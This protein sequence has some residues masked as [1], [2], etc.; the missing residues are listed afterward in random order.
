MTLLGD[1]TM[2]LLNY[3]N[4]EAT[5]TYGY[6]MK[7]IDLE[8]KGWGAEYPLPPNAYSAYPGG[9]EYLF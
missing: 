6:R 4:D 3:F 2:G 7:A 9:G 1:G 5:G 8:N